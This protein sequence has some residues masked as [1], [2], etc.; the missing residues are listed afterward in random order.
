MSLPA[1]EVE[2][3]TGELAQSRGFQP[4]S[5]ADNVPYEQYAAITVRLPD[6]PG[7]SASQGFTRFYP[8]GST[9]GQLVGYV[10]AAS[11]AEYEKENKNP[12]LLIPGVKIGKEGLEQTLEQTLRGEPGGQRVEVTARGKLVKELEP[13]PDRSGNTV[14]LTIDSDLH[15]YAARRIGDQ[16]ASV[17]VI[18]VTNGDI[19]AMPSM[20]SFDPNNFSDGISQN[21]WKML[22][23][24]DHLPLVDKTLESLYPSGSTIKPSMAMALLNAGVDRTQKVNCTGAFQLGNHTFHCDR[25]HGPVDMDAAVVHSCDV[26]F[27]SMCLRVG[28]EKLS[29][30][31]RSMGFGEKFD[32]PFDNQRYGTVPDPEWMMRK[33]HRK[34]QGYDTVNMSIGQGMVLI[35]PLQLAVMASRLATGKRV[36]PRLFKNKPVAPQEHL[37]VD[38]DH[39]DFIRKAMWGVVD[40]GTA[41]AAKLPLSGIQMAGK[42]GTAQTHN[43]AAHE[44]G[45]YTSATWSLRDHS[46]FMAFVPFDNPRYAVATIVEHGGFG[47]AVAAP[48][49]RD[50]ITYL[51]DKQK[52]LAALQTFEESIG[53]PLEQRLARKTAAWRSA[54]GLPPLDPAKA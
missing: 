54:N 24:D 21:E 42:T 36:M 40:H 29:P 27:Y 14:Q 1:D 45:N 41:A 43:L 22:S 44:R 52:A 15:Q 32:L 49:V 16:S 28:A 46:L 5:V 19:L 31:V 8:G 39:L 18:D 9:V 12:L 11:A 20:P 17:V 26:Y 2:R 4:V 7:V 25:R 35:N 48:L 47:A 53:G 23:Q 50:T 3:I 37:E 30:M 38:Q 51:Y 13:K 10:G 34:W 6:L 33:Y